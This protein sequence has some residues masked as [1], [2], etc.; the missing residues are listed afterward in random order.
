MSLLKSC[1]IAIAMY[2]KI[3]MPQFEWEE[4]EMRY[5]VCF[6]PLVGVAIGALTCLWFFIAVRFSV[7]V[8]CFALVGTAIPLLVTGGMHM[9]GYMDTM[10]ALHSYRSTE[11]KLRILKDPHIGAFSVLMLVIYLLLY[12]G[13]YSQ[14]F[15]MREAGILGVGFI[16]SRCL[17]GLALVT[18]PLAKREG[19][20]F[21]FADQADKT[22]VQVV[23]CIEAIA[24]AV[25]MIWL[26]VWTGVVLLVGAVLMFL[27]YRWKSKKE[28]GGITGD[29]EGWFLALMECWFVIGIAIVGRF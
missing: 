12:I 20:L 5:A 29:T 2:S 9:D 22:V 10:D 19:L 27:W 1:A 14:I 11:E 21:T 28:F 18:L 23:L 8:L 6:F 25:L 24:C 13:A 17:S 16:L 26:S 3:P 4:K 7:G 15:T